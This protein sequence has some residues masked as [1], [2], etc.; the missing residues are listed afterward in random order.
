MTP[1]FKSYL[2]Q[3]AKNEGVSI[4]ELVRKRCEE[5]SKADQDQEE[6]EMLAAMVKE[7]QTAV[8]KA[9]SSIDKG[10]KD[11]TNFLDE[12]REKRLSHVGR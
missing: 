2:V 10:L 8:V 3:E 4:S 9:S 1:D 12:L 5:G 6:A 11:A 7:L